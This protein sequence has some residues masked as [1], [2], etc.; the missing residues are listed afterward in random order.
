LINLKAMPLS[1]K[2]STLH[3]LLLNKLMVLYDIEKEL[4]KALPKMAK[5]ATNPDLS[6]G[7]MTHAKETE[8]HVKRLEKCFAA[9]DMKPKKLKSEAIRGLVSDASWVMKNVKGGP[10]LDANLIAAAQY[11]EH[12]EIAGYGTAIEWA[13]LMEHTNVEKLLDQTLTEEKATDEKLTSV[14]KIS[15]NPIVDLGME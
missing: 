9:L 7:F 8:G 12:Y 2:A 5:K 6:K 1:K 4:V 15:V 11:V 13:K 10:A 14:A 3:E